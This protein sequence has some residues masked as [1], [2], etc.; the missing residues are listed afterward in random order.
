MR[1]DEETFKLTET[2]L[3]ANNPDCCLVFG[4]VTGK[5][6]EQ[7]HVGGPNLASFLSG[8][9]HFHCGKGQG[10]GGWWLLIS[11]LVSRKSTTQKKRQEGPN[12]S[13]PVG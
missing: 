7:N 6:R 9:E 4:L 12:H 3:G 11:V 5:A 10:T 1:K 13:S 8:R 2:F